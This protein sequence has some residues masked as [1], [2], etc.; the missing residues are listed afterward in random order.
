MYLKTNKGLRKKRNFQSRFCIYLEILNIQESC[1]IL[2]YVGSF[3][4]QF[5]FFL[6]RVLKHKN[7][8]G[9]CKQPTFFFFFFFFYNFVNPSPLLPTI[10]YYK[11]LG[12]RSVSI[13]PPGSR[14]VS[15]RPPGS[16]V[17]KKI[18]QHQGSRQK[19]LLFLVAGPLRNELFFCGFPYIF[20]QKNNKCKKF[21]SDPLFTET[22]PRMLLTP[23]LFYMGQ[24]GH[25]D[26]L[27]RRKKGV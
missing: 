16:K 19:K 13:R 1:K 5:K 22:D 20:L 9:V 6:S 12:S 11:C 27:L 17:T 14:S 18:E 26:D 15:I 7:V 3:L 10:L 24:F 2:P 21:R 25:D 8:Y 4:F 23:D